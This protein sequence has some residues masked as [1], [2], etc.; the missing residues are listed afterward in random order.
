VK[1]YLNLAPEINGA[2][3]AFAAE[4]KAGDYPDAEYSFSMQVPVED[5]LEK[6]KG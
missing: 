5:L 3:V 1:K 6:G 2:I 4:V